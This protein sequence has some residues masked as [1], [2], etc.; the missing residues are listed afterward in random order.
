MAEVIKN[1]KDIKVVDVRKGLPNLSG[2][3]SYTSP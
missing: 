1:A 2:I 3:D